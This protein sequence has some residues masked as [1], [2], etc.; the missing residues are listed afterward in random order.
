MLSKEVYEKL[1]A[2]TEREQELQRL[3]KS[4][5]TDKVKQTIEKYV[6][7][8][9][10]KGNYFVIEKHTRFLP[11]KEH[12]HNFIEVMYVLNGEIT[13]KIKGKEIVLKKGEL[14][15][16]NQHISHEIAVTTE[17]DIMINFIIKPEFFD[18]IISL[19]GEENRLSR[20]LL[21]SIY[22]NVK[23]GE[24]L[25]FHV[26]EV[27][28]I[29][30]TLEEIIEE[31]YGNS[32]IKNVRIQFLMGLLVVDLIN[33]IPR[34]EAYSE[35]SYDEELLLKILKY[36]QEYYDSA[37]LKELSINLNQ[38][39]YKLSK[40]IKEITGKTFQGLVLEKKLEK[41]EELLKN[42]DYSIAE[43]IREIGYEN[44]TYFYKIFNNKYNMS[45]KE[46]R[47]IFRKNL[48]TICNVIKK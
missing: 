35:E 38:P 2:F 1:L 40:F 9:F 44:M 45:P 19:I 14:M 42:T 30:S 29:Q 22:N 36:I 6:E 17:E 31:T 41:S 33:N 24:Y 32:I 21:S 39:N 34:L 8:K 10:S 28:R 13:Q 26:S 27:G 23:K 5:G 25:C 11:V 3:L 7:G 47:E 37:S 16:L 12:F 18:H 43:I 4:T 46:Y 15:L 48:I 20:F